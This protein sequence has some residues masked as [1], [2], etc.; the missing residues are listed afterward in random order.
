MLRQEVSGDIYDRGMQVAVVTLQEKI[1]VLPDGVFRPAYVAFVPQLAGALG[2][3]LVPLGAT[4]DA[5]EAVISLTPVAAGIRF[6]PTSASSDL[7]NLRGKPLTLNFGDM[8]I[9]VSSFDPSREETIDIY[10]AL[11]EAVTRGEAQT[12]AGE[13][14]KLDTPAQYDGGFLSLAEPPVRGVVPGTAVYVTTSGVQCLFRQE[15]ANDWVAVPVSVL[16]PA[17]GIL[18][19]VY[20]GPELIDA[21]IARDP[22]ILTDDVLTGC[23]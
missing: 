1:G 14:D 20:V 22:L 4:V 10:A 16:E 6:N 15:S 21:P 18:G 12:T 8:R 13:V 2:K 11:L 9:P 3:P 23:Q 17:V 7:S 5:G 19:A